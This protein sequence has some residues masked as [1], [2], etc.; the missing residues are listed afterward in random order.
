MAINIKKQ[1]KIGEPTLTAVIVLMTWG[2]E[3]IRDFTITLFLGIIVGTYSS[4][5]VASPVV[6]LGHERAQRRAKEKK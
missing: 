1:I 4:V 6:Y 3:V 2:G 5:F